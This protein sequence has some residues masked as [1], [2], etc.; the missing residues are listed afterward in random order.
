[1]SSIYLDFQHLVDE[2]ADKL[3]LRSVTHVVLMQ[4]R[5]AALLSGG[6]PHYLP[7]A[8]HGGGTG[9]RWASAQDTSSG[10]EWGWLSSVRT[11]WETFFSPK[12]G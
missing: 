8:E 12:A 1:M 11:F 7:L 3:C 5:M 4:F 2:G 9:A 10:A 6:F